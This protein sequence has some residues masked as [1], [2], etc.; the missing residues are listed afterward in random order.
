MADG[1]AD[2]E[3]QANG[4]NDHASLHGY[5]KLAALMG[6]QPTTMIFRRFNN[7]AI[8]NILRLQAELQDMER[9]LFEEIARDYASQD[10]TERDYCN[11][12]Y[13]MRDR[14]KRRKQAETSPRNSQEGRDRTLVDGQ[15]LLS[16]KQIELITQIG[17]KLQEYGTD[18][19]ESYRLNI[20]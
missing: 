20:F 5:P 10:E 17:L 16:T 19:V 18:P 7:V 12:F 6:S 4:T 8:L 15:E 14:L 13:L 11:D 2:Q 3:A 1:Q 9:L